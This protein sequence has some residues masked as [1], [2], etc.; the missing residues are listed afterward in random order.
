MRHRQNRF[1]LRVFFEDC[2]GQALTEFVI[3][4][5]VMVAVAAWL[6][7]NNNGMYEGIRRTY[8]K[9]SIILRL[10]GP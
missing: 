6:Y 9:T 7:N 2:R 10:P 8:D 5:A 1:W 3:V 4:T